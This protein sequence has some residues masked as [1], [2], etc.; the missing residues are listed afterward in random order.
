MESPSRG[1]PPAEGGYFM[2]GINGCILTEHHAGTCAIP[3]LER[4]RSRTEKKAESNGDES[5]LCQEASPEETVTREAEAMAPAA[6][7]VDHASNADTSSNADADEARRTTGRKITGPLRLGLDDGWAN[8]P[9]NKWSTQAMPG[10]IPADELAGADAAPAGRGRSPSSLLPPKKASKSLHEAVAAHTGGEREGKTPAGASRALSRQASAGSASGSNGSAQYSASGGASADAARRSFRTVQVPVRL[11]L[12]D[13]WSEASA[14]KW[15]SSEPCAPNCKW[16]SS[17][18]QVGAPLPT[19]AEDVVS[20][21]FRLHG[22]SYEPPT[23]TPLPLVRTTAANTKGVTN[24]TNLTNRKSEVATDGAVSSAASEAP[25]G[26]PLNAVSSAS[27]RGEK[28]A[29]PVPS[30]GGGSL[31]NKGPVSLLLRNAR[32]VLEEYQSLEQARHGG[33]A[34][35]GELGE[36]SDHDGAEV[37]GEPIDEPSDSMDETGSIDEPSGSGAPRSAEERRR[38]AAKDGQAAELEKQQRK[39]QRLRAKEQRKRQRQQLR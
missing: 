12:N 2:C 34:A 20:V 39:Q 29:V 22:A 37:G 1:S 18:A 11:G 28:R 27:S 33:Q 8:E 36:E 7:S 13:D 10:A 17:E 6:S 16:T 5:K 31:S 30:S 26:P 9:A 4:K 35:Q 25:R 3:F 19:S 24:L 14:S 32:R 21:R 23:T 15:T 38:S